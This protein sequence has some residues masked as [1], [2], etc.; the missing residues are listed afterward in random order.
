MENKE[1]LSIALHIMS[2]LG[3]HTE[4]SVQSEVGHK[5]VVLTLE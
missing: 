4:E 1:S 5:Q 3:S 2:I